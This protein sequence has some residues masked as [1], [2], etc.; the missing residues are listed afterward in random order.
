MDKFETGKQKIVHVCFLGRRETF[1][2]V[3]NKQKPPVIE[4]S[5]MKEKPAHI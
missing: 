2:E 4:N 3:K 5:H 1:S